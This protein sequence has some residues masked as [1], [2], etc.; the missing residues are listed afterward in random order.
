MLT[1]TASQMVHLLRPILAY[2]LQHFG[3]YL[4]DKC[5]N[6]VFQ[7]VIWSGLVYIDVRSHDLC[8]Q[9][10]GAEYENVYWTRLSISPFLPVLCGMWQRLVETTCHTSQA[11]GFWAKKGEYHLTVALTVHSYVTIRSIFKEVRSNDATRPLTVPNYFLDA[12][13][14]LAMLLADILQVLFSLCGSD[15][16]VCWFFFS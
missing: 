13:V 12:L 8:G 7:C 14:A 4:T 5:F 11:L 16:W 1:T 6:V 10:T 2:S 15:K 9:L 3:R